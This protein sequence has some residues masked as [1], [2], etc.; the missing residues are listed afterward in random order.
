MALGTSDLTIMMEDVCVTMHDVV[1]VVH[2][3]F[4]VWTL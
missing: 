1:K 4:K 3:K 2:L